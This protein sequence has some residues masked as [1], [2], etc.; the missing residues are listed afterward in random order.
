MSAPLRLVVLTEVGRGPGLGH[1]RRC[2]ALG[3]AAVELGAHA[4][5]LVAGDVPVEPSRDGRRRLEFEPCNWLERSDVGVAALDHGPADVVIVDSYAATAAFLESLGARV[6]CAVLLDDLA[7]RATPVD[8]VV[9][10][11]FHA[12]QLRYRGKPDGVYLLG[13]RYAL[14]SRSGRPRIMIAS[15]SIAASPRS[16]P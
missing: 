11:G 16:G 2:M 10:G 14:P 13:P 7:D 4:R 1:F 5:L 15:A 3:L 12:P 6:P 8:V 9:N